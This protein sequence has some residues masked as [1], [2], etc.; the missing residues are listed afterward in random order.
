MPRGSLTRRD[1]ELVILRVAHLRRCRYELEHHRRLARRAG[2]DAEAVQ[3][4]LAGP[5]AQGWSAR[6]RVLLG[7]VDSLLIKRDI[8]DDAW[9]SL[10][11][12]FA[13]AQLVELCLLVGHY[14][15]LAMTIA[16]LRV[17]PDFG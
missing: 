12:H 15:M 3:R 10:S 16:A 2:L 11:A 8:E 7:A 14:D 17:A 13:M 4:V 5:T 1:T 6:D 9:Q